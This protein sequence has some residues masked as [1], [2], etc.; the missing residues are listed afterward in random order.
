M[1]RIRLLGG[2][3]VSRDDQRLVA[4]AATQPRRL[5]ILATVASAGDLGIS[6][7]RLQA[8]FWP[9]ADEAIARRALTQALYGLRTG[10]DDEQLLLGVQELRLNREIAACDI[11]EYLDAI[12][13]GELERA[14]ALY[15]GPFLDG[16]RVA[17]AADFNRRVDEQR[18]E[19]AKRQESLLVRLAAR[20]SSRGECD[21][22]VE[23]WRQR[24]AMDRFDAR[25][26]EAY[27]RAL[28]AAGDTVGAI[29]YARVHAQLV[30]Q[31]FGTPVSPAVRALMDTLQAAEEPQRPA[32]VLVPASTRAELPAITPAASA[33]AASA[34]AASAP[35]VETPVAP[36]PA[37]ATASVPPTPVPAAPRAPRR[38][39]VGAAVAAVGV[40]AVLSLWSARRV[41]GVGMDDAELGSLR[42]SAPRRIAADAMFELD[43]AISPDGDHIAYVVGD[44]GAMRLYVRQRDGGRALLIAESVE[45][46][47]RRPRWSPDGASIAFQ[48]A[49]GV[50]LVPALGGAARLVVES[51]ASMRAF[52]TSPTWSPDGRE[53]AWVAGDSIYR[54]AVGDG[55]RATRRFVARVAD[56]HSLA[57]SP[58]GQWIAAV[59]GNVQ[60]ALGAS[61]DVSRAGVSVGNLAPSAIV[62]VAAAGDSTVGRIADSVR[63]LVPPFTLNTSPA[64]L[65]KRTLIFVS[66]RDGTR[67]L[68]AVHVSDAGTL[69]GDVERIS[70]G[71]DAHSVSAS[72]DG[73]QL[74]YAVFRQSAN[75]W[76]LPLRPDAAATLAS[77]K[78]VTQGTQVVEGLDV[79]QDGRWLAYDADVS[80][81]QDIFRLALVDGAPA[82]RDAERVVSSAVDDF[83]PSWSPDARWLAFYTF[84]GGVRRAAYVAASGDAERLVHP[85]GPNVEEHSPVWSSDGRSLLYWRGERTTSNL[86]RTMRLGD[87]TWSAP[88]RATSSGGMGPSFSMDGRQMVYFQSAGTVRLTDSTLRESTSHVIL[89]PPASAG[90]GPMTASAR[91]T[92]D[93]RALISKGHDA[94]SSGFWW[95]PLADGVLGA[96]RLLVRF[97]DPRRSSPRGEFTTDGRYL[98]FTLAEREADVWVLRLE[99]Q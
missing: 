98:F 75:I 64:W 46:D 8:L 25:V 43:P 19:F 58:D 76:S 66:S 73:R 14:A 15:Q 95:Y 72:A 40:A 88:S 86:F 22:A 61:G 24:A 11:A 54:M 41:G 71:L 27:M 68:F 50:W 59:S 74:A 29:R 32:P 77:A 80:G 93:G 87:S 6:R 28:V 23:W 79:S 96:P 5:A 89:S 42:V 47:Q 10:I 2:L 67:D 51:P 34:T 1:I 3:S 85:T 21:R 33:P 4:P 38:L 20:A 90:T 30:E 12:A 83:H 48:S 99:R 44:E 81:Q 65:D 52:S 17:G 60:F 69:R 55:T 26:A 53:I 97:D 18:A 94:V 70:A 16:F 57:W 13:G 7:D 35:A 82:N 92:P 36:A 49:S 63:V 62:L 39:F 37:V 78:R 9:D 91:I 31:E 45:G 56:A 84:R